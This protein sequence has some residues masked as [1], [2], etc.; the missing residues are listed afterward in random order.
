MTFADCAAGPGMKHREA[1]DR[2]TIDWRKNRVNR[3]RP[4]GMICP[5]HEKHPL[6]WKRYAPLQGSGCRLLRRDVVLL[7]RYMANASMLS[8]KGA[9]RAFCQRC[10][11]LSDNM[12]DFGVKR[13]CLT[14]PISHNPRRFTQNKMYPKKQAGFR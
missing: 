4:Y 3:Y 8:A 13:E 9:L 11:A 12:R 5:E 1:G 14:S 2:N 6:Q 10:Q 7:C